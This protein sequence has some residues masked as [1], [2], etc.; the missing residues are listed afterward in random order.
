MSRSVLR[1]YLRISS[2][3]RCPG[4]YR[5][6]RGPEGPTGDV[7][8]GLGEHLPRSPGRGHSPGRAR[9]GE[10]RG[11]GGGGGGGEGEGEGR[12]GRRWGVVLR[13]RGLGMAQLAPAGEGRWG[14][15]GRTPGSRGSP[16]LRARTEPG[17]QLP[18]SLAVTSL[19]SH[20]WERDH[21]CRLPP[22]APYLPQE[23][24]TPPN[25]SYALQ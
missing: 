16:L 18:A 9:R 15:E 12:V 20:S 21:A 1:W 3:A 24:P 10:R 2:S 6:R 4:R 7:S 5:R 11:G 19:S 22:G 17:A 13:A 25:P 14:V 8:G 23:E